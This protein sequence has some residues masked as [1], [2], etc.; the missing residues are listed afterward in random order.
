MNPTEHSSLIPDQLDSSNLEDSFIAV[1]RNQ[2]TAVVYWSLTKKNLPYYEGGK[3]CL[4]VV[5]E[6]SGNKETIF[7]HRENGHFIVPLLS[8][9][10]KYQIEIGWADANGFSKFF[11]EAIELDHRSNYESQKNGLFSQHVGSAN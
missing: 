4:Q 9:E 10:R 11:G 8:D 6:E 5:A 2:D 7:L 1:P 3:L